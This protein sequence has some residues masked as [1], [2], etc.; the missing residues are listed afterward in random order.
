[1]AKTSDQLLLEFEFDLSHLHH[2]VEHYKLDEDEGIKKFKEL[3]MAAKQ[4]EY[5]KMVE[6]A[7]MPT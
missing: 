5:S 2:G 7:M 6:K 4:S 3:I 1:M